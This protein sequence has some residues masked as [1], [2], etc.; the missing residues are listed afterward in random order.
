M[1]ITSAQNPR[2]KEVAKLLESRHRR[3]TGLFLVE[4]DREIT[5]ALEHGFE[6][7]ELYWCPRLWP[8]QQSPQSLF[9]VADDRIIEV[10]DAVLAKLTVSQ[11]PQGTVAVFVQKQ[12]DVAEL[13]AGDG[14]GL[15]LVTVGIEKPGNLGAMAR[16]A[17]SAGC[18]GMLVCNATGQADLYNPNAIRAS[19]GALF[20][21]PMVSLA[22][23]DTLSMLIE[24]GVQIV[25]TSDRAVTSWDKVDFAKPTAIVIGPED[26]GLS[27]V[28][29]KANEHILPV[30]IPMLGDNCDSLNAS[31]AAGILLYEAVRQRTLR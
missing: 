19:T 30:S 24:Q 22:E 1:L 26:T 16:T 15:W 25:T 9:G 7:A 18:R 8:E 21:L 2:I 5:R 3:K 20:S 10:S 29:L 14:A 6:P 28:W 17:E 12:W 31:V 13:F 23:A 11:N 27:A 4:R